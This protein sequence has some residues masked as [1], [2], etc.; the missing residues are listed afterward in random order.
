M[1]WAILLERLEL[2]WRRVRLMAR[3]P[4]RV[5]HAIN[6]LASL[7]LFER[8]AAGPGGVLVPVRQA[9]PAEPGKVHEVDVLHVG[10]FPKMFDEPPECRR[11]EFGPRR[12]IKFNHLI[13]PGP[14][15]APLAWEKD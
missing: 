8:Q 14:R 1:L 5:G 11:L 13:A 10:P 12:D 7:A 3:L 15:A 2:L 6:D 9:I 4:L